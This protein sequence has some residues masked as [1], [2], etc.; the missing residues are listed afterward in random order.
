MHFPKYWALHRED[1]GMSWQ[2]S[3]TSLAEA[4]ARAQAAAHKAAVKFASG[5]PLQRYGYSDR[6]LREEVLREIRD[7]AGALTAVITRNSYGCQVLNTTRAM[8]VDV[9][10]PEPKPAAAVGGWLK[11]LFGKPAA[12]PPTPEDPARAVLAKAD[13]WAQQNAGWGWRV[14]RTKAGFRLL[15]TH[16]L[17]DPASPA[18]E[19]VFEAMGTDPLYRRLCKVQEC[20]RARLTPKPW[21]CDMETPPSRWPWQSPKQESKHREWEARYQKATTGFATCALVATLGSRLVHPELQSI[22]TLHDEATRVGT[23]LPLA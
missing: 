2:W 10:L 18:V 5:E 3:D 22:V 4:Q 15:A 12:P 13:A 14:Y 16:A 11:S 19:A 8:F 20:F 17:F 7:G 21:R 9:D 1:A 23:V 6:P